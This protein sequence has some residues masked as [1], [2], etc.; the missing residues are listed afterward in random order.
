MVGTGLGAQRG[1]LFKNA[2]ALETAAHVDVVVCD[3]TGTLTK[4][5]P[6]VTDVITSGLARGEVL[7]FA[8]ALERESEHPLARAVVAA[9]D[10]EDA[11]VLSAE[12]FE[13][14]RG[15]GAIAVVAGRQVVIGSR[16]LLTDRGIDTDA[17]EPRRAELAEGGRTAIF[18]AIDGVAVAVIGMADA[19]RPTSALMVRGLREL[20]IAVVMLTGD[21]VAT[22]RRIAAGWASTT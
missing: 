8:A 12:G 16:R 10:A 17:L 9:A 7:A 21:N 15:Q 3:K 14:V 4:G 5:E 1:V 2:A 22:A 18:V 6:E 11:E 19:P 13:N 20:G